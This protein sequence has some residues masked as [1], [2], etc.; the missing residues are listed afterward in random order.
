MAVEYKIIY[1]GK[2][3]TRDLQ[4]EIESIIYRDKTAGEA[5]ELTIVVKDELHRWKDSWNP[6]KGD[7]I[8]AQIID[9]G[10]VL[11]CGDFTVDEI[12]FSGSPD[13]QR[14]TLMALSAGVKDA[15]RTKTCFK[16]EGKTLKEIAQAYADKYKAKLQGIIHNYSI[17]NAT[18]MHETDLGFLHRLAEEH[19]YLFTVRGDKWIFTYLPELN[20]SMKPA[21][22]ITMGDA[23]TIGLYPF[24]IVDKVAGVFVKG[25]NRYH[26]SKKKAVFQTLVEAGANPSVDTSATREHVD[27]DQQGLYKVDGRL[28]KKNMEQVELKGTMPG[29][30]N[31]VAG[32]NVTIEGFY[33]YNGKY[34]CTESMHVLNSGVNYNTT[35]V[36]KR[37][38]PNVSTG[39]PKGEK[40]N[41][42]AATNDVN[43]APT[44]VQE[45]IS[46]L[47]QL[48]NDELT[49]Q[50]F[51]SA[52][53]GTL[54]DLCSKLNEEKCGHGDGDVVGA[55][56]DDIHQLLG[57]GKVVSANK[58][59]V[60][61]RNKLQARLDAGVYK[62]P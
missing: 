29:N 1:E 62:N 20:D 18:Q 27:D 59:I 43:N 23:N 33:K 52:R 10:N 50:V 44:I 19:G 11:D 53:T 8:S 46:G 41:Y 15:V 28:Y 37:I 58:Y 26:H 30:V 2:D 17:A 3:I 34:M 32:V 61:S 38:L 22:T 16:H 49:L 36:F 57:D 25:Q 9:G 54:D 45:I 35:P 42:P 47:Q 4:G 12:H 60:S 13:G 6:V 55:Y 5:D 24:E 51:D 31:V 40:V 39:N 48:V 7:K 56:L 14:A 21:L